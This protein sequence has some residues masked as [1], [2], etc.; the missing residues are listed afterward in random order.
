MTNTDNKLLKMNYLK[1]NKI[2]VILFSTLVFYIIICQSCMTMR[3]SKSKTKTFFKDSHTTYIDSTIA[4]GESKIHYIQTGKEDH[5]TLF[6]IHGSPGSWNNFQDFLKDTLLLKK[7]RMIAIDRPGFGFSNF[8]EA[9]DL[10]VQ[11]NLIEEFVEKIKN[12]KNIYLI[13]HSYGGPAIV[14]MA[15]DKPNNYKQIVILAGAI[16]PYAENPET[17]RPVFMSK[18][19]RYLIP[20]ALR[21]ANDELWWLKNDLFRMKPN[22]KKVTTNVVIIHGTKDRLVPFSNVDFMKK[23]FLNAKSVEEIS[24][25]DADHFLPWSHY[26][27]IRNK[28]LDLKE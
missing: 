15:I 17:W 6:F 11:S 2:K 12:G 16:D 28:L 8:G 20:G 21:P 23:E 27:I 25:K 22:L 1:R 26:E 5:P 24:I 7:Y 18:P 4:I 9:Q 14:K 3:S 13:G 19:L 10:Y